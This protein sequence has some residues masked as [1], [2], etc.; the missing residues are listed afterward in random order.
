MVTVSNLL[1]TRVQNSVTN[2]S[3]HSAIT[4]SYVDPNF[5]ARNSD[6]KTIDSRKYKE[7]TLLDN[8]FANRMKISVNKALD[9]PLVHFPRGLGGA[10]DY[11]FFEFL[12]RAKFPY[13]VGGPIL[14]A[15]FYAGVKKDSLKSSVAAKAVAKRMA[16]GVAL[17]YAGAALAKSIVNT[18][19]K[20]VRGVDLKHPYAKAISTS[21]NQTGVFKKDVE[22]H[23]AYESTEFTRTDLLYKKD[24]NTPEQINE[25]YARLGK[26]FGVKGDVNDVDQSVKPLLK[27]TIIMARAWQYALTAFFVTLGIGMANQPAWTAESAQGFKKTV[28][29]GIFGKNVPISDRIK[30]AKIAVY[31][32]GIRPIGRSFLEFWKGNGTKASSVAGKSVIIATGLATLT[33]ISLLIGK[34]SARGHKVE[35]SGAN[36]INEGVQ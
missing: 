22:Y 24:G 30:N 8:T 2:G 31:D 28:T 6:S 34:T 23:S 18:T 29:N 17:Y 35:S 4:K 27:K 12:Q 26:K 33:A 7:D 13:Y 1:N 21:T 3:L 14:A 16:T 9:I 25:E 11:S 5:Q 36:K 32:Y 20:L 15:L 19:T 10:P